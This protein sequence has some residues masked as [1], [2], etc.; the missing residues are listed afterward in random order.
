MSFSSIS[1][2]V[3]LIAELPSDTSSQRREAISHPYDLP[4]F[5]DILSSLRK[6]YGLRLNKGGFPGPEVKV[7]QT[8]LGEALRRDGIAKSTATVSETEASYG[9]PRNPLLFIA[10]ISRILD[11]NSGEMEMLLLAYSVDLTARY[12]PND[13]YDIMPKV[14]TPEAR[15]SFK[16]RLELIKQG[17][18]LPELENEDFRAYLYMVKGK[19]LTT[20]DAK[21]VINGESL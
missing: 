21:R 8:S 2:I 12:L 14:S 19:V 11:L 16:H 20:Q 6:A 5:G 13:V 10:G 1:D 9:L 15:E 4:T 18:R 3:L 17:E 7:T